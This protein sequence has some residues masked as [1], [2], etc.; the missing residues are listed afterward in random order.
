METGQGYS[1][2]LSVLSPG[3][4]QKQIYGKNS[5]KN[6]WLYSYFVDYIHI[7]A[8]ITYFLT[9]QKTKGGHKGPTDRP[10]LGKQPHI[11]FVLADDY[12]ALL[13]KFFENYFKWLTPYVKD[14]MILVI[15][16]LKF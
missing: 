3:Y 13:I 1:G 16:W 14:I 8:S 5:Q 15:I 10:A 11:L 9:L 12:G 2:R 6:R 7:S 4:F